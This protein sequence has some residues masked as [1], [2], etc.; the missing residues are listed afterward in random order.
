D[1]LYCRAF[2]DLTAEPIILQIPA[3]GDRPYWFPIGDI[4]HNLNASL[5][6]D[7]VGGSG[8]AFALCPPG[9]EGLMPAGVERVDV[10]TPY[11]WM[12]GRYYVSGVDDV[13]AVN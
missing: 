12:I 10:R 3:T 1:T 6:W 4:Y 5:S 13:P 9:F 7:T 8:G 11:I 2:L